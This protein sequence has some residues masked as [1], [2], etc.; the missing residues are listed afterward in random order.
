MDQHDWVEV[1]VLI[2]LAT[3]TTI[4]VSVC[5]FGVATGRWPTL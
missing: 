2:V 1:L 4:V 3:A 5:M